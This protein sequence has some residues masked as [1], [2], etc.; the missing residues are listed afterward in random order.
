MLLQPFY[1]TKTINIIIIII[2][3]IKFHIAYIIVAYQKRV[4]AG[5]YHH[6]SQNQPLGEAEKNGV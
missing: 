3:T 4:I 1:S 6:S 2:V 5:F